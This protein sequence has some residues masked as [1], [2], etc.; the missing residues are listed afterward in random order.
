MYLMIVVNLEFTP[1]TMIRSYLILNSL[2]ILCFILDSI[3][4]S[5]TTK[6]SF[7]LIS[8]VTF[9][10][11]YNKPIQGLE[12]LFK[13][14]FIKITPKSKFEN[15]QD[16]RRLTIFILIGIFYIFILFT[17]IHNEDKSWLFK[18]IITI[19][20]PLAVYITNHHIYSEKFEHLMKEQYNSIQVKKESVEEILITGELRFKKLEKREVMAIIEIFKGIIKDESLKDFRN[21][22][23]K[24]GIKNKIICVDNSK[25]GVFRYKNLFKLM[26]LILHD[27]NTEFR[28]QQRKDML[29]LLQNH[30]VKEEKNVILELNYKSMEGAYSSFN[31]SE[32]PKITIKTL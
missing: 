31:L 29:L 5:G 18:I 3:Y 24:E 1:F 21:F 23:Q 22:I 27:N 9:L 7:F 6:I 14:Y 10:M 20:I 30:F 2:L 26:H 12:K 13:R 11:I 8:L 4:N 15:Y 19:S 25:T 16:N 28:G 32:V 17:W